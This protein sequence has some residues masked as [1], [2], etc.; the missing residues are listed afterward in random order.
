MKLSKIIIFLLLFATLCFSSNSIIKFRGVGDRSTIDKIIIANEMTGDSLLLSGTEMISLKND[1]IFAL[2]TILIKDS[3]RQT[4]CPNPFENFTDIYFPSD[5]NVIKISVSNLSGH[6]LYQTRINNTKVNC[7]YRFYASHKGVYLVNFQ[8]GRSSMTVRSICVMSSFQK[9]LIEVVPYGRS[10]IRNSIVN[11]SNFLKYKSGD[12]LKYSCSSMGLKTVIYDQPDRDTTINVYFR[13]PNEQKLNWWKEAKLGLYIHWGLY[14]ALEGEWQN[15]KTIGSGVAE[16]IQRLFMIPQT[17]YE[18]Y[19]PLFTASQFNAD[20][21]AKLAKIAGLKYV[22]LTVKH[23]DGFLLF[24]SKYTDYTISRTPADQDVVKKL[25]IACRKNGLKFGVYFSQN[26][27][28]YHV[29]GFD[30][31]KNNSYYVNNGNPWSEQQNKEYILNNVIPIMSEIFQNFAPDVFWYDGPWL[32]NNPALA[33][34]IKNFTDSNVSENTI[35]NNRL[36]KQ[37]TGDFDTP[38]CTWEHEYEDNNEICFTLNDTWGYDKN[39]TNFKDYRNI[40]WKIIESASRNG[41]TLL[42]IGPKADGTV[43]AEEINILKSVG[44]W[45]SFNGSAIY[46]TKLVNRKSHQSFGR[47]TQKG[48]TLYAI[49]LDHNLTDIT[50]EGIETNNLVYVTTIDN[51]LLPHTIVDNEIVN[52]SGLPSP[53]DFEPRVVK[54][55]FSSSIHSYDRII[56]N[57]NKKEFNSLC[58]KTFGYATVQ[59]F[60]D[61]L[62]VGNWE[63]SCR[64]VSNIYNGSSSG[65][66]NVFLKVQGG[67][68]L[69]YVQMQIGEATIQGIPNPNPNGYNWDIFQYRKIGSVYLEQGQTYPIIIK[70][71]SNGAWSYMNLS[72]I[73][74]EKTE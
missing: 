56:L 16:W 54:L 10:S 63:D 25:S 31:N 36:Q 4:I 32:N 58:F 61:S 60:T 39:A 13:P 71:S 46:G 2:E 50:V 12:I 26:M 30:F 20:S 48:D 44:K 27:D 41:N 33:Q 1:S 42:N 68:Y 6:L 70:K 21:I 55:V 34:Y 69:K 53:Q 15:H 65:M 23:H 11:V 43:P 45:L 7:T 5:R 3:K 74:L 66:Y 35:F 40:L 28:W 73:K 62:N 29:G 72:G 19:L 52:I 24:P 59:G 18:S 14:S 57:S 17:E 37:F 22:V 64:F 38:E 67:D 47:L 51:K 49:I 9:F 8:D